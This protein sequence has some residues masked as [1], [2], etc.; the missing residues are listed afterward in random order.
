MDSISHIR[1]AE[2]EEPQKKRSGSDQGK[3]HKRAFQNSLGNEIAIFLFRY[4]KVV[5]Q[6]LSQHPRMCEVM[7][8]KTAP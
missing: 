7:R 3:D 1:A 5:P 8:P 6:S 2:D 4:G